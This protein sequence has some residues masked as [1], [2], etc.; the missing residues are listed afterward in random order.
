MAVQRFLAHMTWP[1]V[2]ALDKSKAVA[3]LPVG[4]T[5]QHGHHL[6]IYTDTIISSG[7]LERA[8][9]LLPDDIPAYRLSPIT[10]SKSNEHR[11]FPGTIWIGAKT[12]YDVLFDIGR[13]VHESGFRKLCF[14]NGHGGNIGILHAVTRDI[15]DEFGMTTFFGSAGTYLDETVL[16]EGVD[17][18]ENQFGIHA[19][20][21]ET[22]LIKALT[23]EL[24]KE[25][26]AKPCFPDYPETGIG[27]VGKGYAQWKTED[28][29]ATGVF[30]DPTH[31]TDEI[32][33]DYLERSVQ[34]TIKFLKEMVDFEYARPPI[35]DGL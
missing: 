32:A 21:T 35:E 7:V 1:E 19:N 11:G 5:E 9:D 28:W 33:A 4:A 27:L 23:P 20:F 10:I 24:V 13:S 8:M 15:R 12:L 3:V 22:A 16:P 29:S 34:G 6:P 25:D 17:P 30:G 26:K 2:K 18:R 31:V 14:F